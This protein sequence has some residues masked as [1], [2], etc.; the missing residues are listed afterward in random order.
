MNIMEFVKKRR[1]VRTFDG[2]G[3]SAS[4][5]QKL[6]DYVKNI[7][8]PYGIPV[9]FLL[10]DAKEQ[11]LF[12][13][14]IDG[15]QY[16][17]IGKVPMVLHSEE[18]FGY[19]FEKMVLYAQS[20]GLGT[21][22]MAGTLDRQ[23][24]EKA[25]ALHDDEIMYC[26]S[27]VGYAATDM[28]A[29]EQKMRTAIHADERKAEAELFFAN[30]FETPLVETDEKI[31]EALEAVRLGPSAV[32]YQPWR[33][34]KVDNAFHF[35]EAHTKSLQERASW[36]VQKIDMGIALCHFMSVAGGNCSL[37][38][39]DIVCPEGTEYIATVTV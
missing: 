6:C 35:Y 23:I 18:A 3:I 8:N 16:Y 15:E 37:A 25:A 36:D 2:K 30:S 31:K 17:I 24:F 26:V 34:V 21:T 33:I 10:V 27:P 28:S 14:V 13:P 9:E 5:Y 32:N 20:L 22:W 19:S 11:G 1:S 38:E 29:K 39:P 4:D 12:S 7:E